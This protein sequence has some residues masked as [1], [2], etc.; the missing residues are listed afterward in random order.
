MNLFFSF[1]RTLYFEHPFRN[2]FG[3]E[4]RFIIEIEDAE[5]KVVTN[6]EEWTYLRRCVRMVITRVIS[7]SVVR[8]RKGGVTRIFE[9]I[10][11]VY[12]K[13]VT[14]PNSCCTYNTCPDLY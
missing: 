7:Y 9:F 6:T 4:E 13:R 11:P 14:P 1:G 8:K 3:Q 10:F 12:S 5:L 2:P